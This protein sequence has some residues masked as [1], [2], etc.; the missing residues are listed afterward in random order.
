LIRVGFWIDIER[1]V[2]EVFAYLTDPNSLWEWQETHEV[3]QLTD[4]PLGRGTR[5]REVH[6]MLGRRLETITEVVAYQPDQRFDV[7]IASGPVPIDGSWELESMTTGTRVHFSA[8]G[9][10]PAA[11]R[12]LEPLLAFAMRRRFRRQHERLKRA[13]ERRASERA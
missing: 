7:C 2:H 8:E 6:L 10:C 11:A 13:V 3:E 5:F 9:R 12:L 1:P 4:G